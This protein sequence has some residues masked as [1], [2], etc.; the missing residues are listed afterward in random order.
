MRKKRLILLVAAV[1]VA[2]AGVFIFLFRPVASKEVTLR[3]VG[4]DGGWS[5]VNEMTFWMTNHTDKTFMITLD[6]VEIQ[7]GKGWTTY[8]NFPH[9]YWLAINFWNGVSVKSPFIAP[10]AVGYGATLGQ[11]VFL[12]TNVTFRIRAVMKE[13]LVGIGAI[14]TGVKEIPQRVQFQKQHNLIVPMNP[15]NK[16]I[17]R[18]G[19]ASIV[20][21]EPVVPK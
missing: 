16:D 6:A 9:P 18:W 20:V 21:S 14:V 12:P 15:L 8:T 7:S 19:K 11:V 1:L 2:C 5:A 4:P 17:A 3:Y 10:H 13:R